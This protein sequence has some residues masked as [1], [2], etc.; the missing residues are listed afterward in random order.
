MQ[1]SQFLNRCY[2]HETPITDKDGNIGPRL[3]MREMLSVG[4]TYKVSNRK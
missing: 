1:I 4:L 2:D 3:Q